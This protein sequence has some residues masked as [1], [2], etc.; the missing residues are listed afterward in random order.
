MFRRARND[1]GERLLRQDRRARRGNRPAPDETPDEVAPPGIDT[2]RAADVSTVGPW[3][4]GDVPAS[5][6]E[7]LDL[8]SLQVLVHDEMEIRLQV[9][10]DDTVASVLGLWEESAVELAAFAA[11]RS[12]GLWNDVRAEI[13]G[14]AAQQ[15][16]EVTDADGRF[17]PELQITVAMTDP[18]TGDTV[19]QPQRLWGVDGPRWFLRAN[20]LGRAAVDDDVLQPIEAFVRD[21]VVIRGDAPMAPRERLVLSMPELPVEGSLTDGAGDGD[22]T[23]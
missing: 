11:P 19:V 1:S 9:G 23:D 17:G 4:V 15:G 22:P 14:E 8:G 12:G 13:A 5:E 10:E 16:G 18:E 7:R 21:I 2:R 20:V 6:A 3:D